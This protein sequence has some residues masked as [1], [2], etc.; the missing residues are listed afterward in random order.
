MHMLTLVPV[1]V[2]FL[3]MGGEVLVL[4]AHAT[5]TKPCCNC[6]SCNWMC[7]CRGTNIHCPGCAC[8]MGNSYAFQVNAT[9]MRSDVT[10]R[11]KEVTRGGKRLG[12]NLTLNLLDNADGLRLAC[13]RSDE[14]NMGNT[15]LQLVRLYVETEDAKDHEAAVR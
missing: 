6:C 5:H 14:K 11:L 9:A 15:M 8:H 10:E 2:L 1:F 4:P 13:L 7:T 12:G 3:F